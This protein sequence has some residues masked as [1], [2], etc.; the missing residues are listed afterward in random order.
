LLLSSPDVRFHIKLAVCQWLN[1]VASPSDAEFLIVSQFDQTPDKFHVLFRQAV[2]SPNWFDL[3]NHK[4]WITEQLESQ[5]SDR[6]EQMFW[7]FRNIAEE[8]PKEIADLLRS[9]WNSKPIRAERLLDWFGFVR[10]NKVD[11]QLLDLCIELIL[12]HPS[13]LFRNDH[14]VSM[15]LHNWGTG[16]PE[17]CGRVL[18]ALF[19]AW[20]ASTSGDSPFAKNNSDCLDEHRLKEISDKMPFAF[21]YGTTD[22][23]IKTIDM[24]ADNVEGNNSWHLLNYRV[25]SGHHYGFDNFLAC[26][27]SAL[28]QAMKENP[29]SAIG[30]LDKLDPFKHECLMHLHL[31]MIQANPIMLGHRLPHLVSSANIFDAGF[32]GANWW[33]FAHACR[34]TFPVLDMAEKQAVERVILNCYPEIEHSKYLRKQI[35]TEGESEP[36]WTKRSVIWWL[37]RTGYEQWCILETIGTN[38]LT[39]SGQTR[40][41]ALQRKFPHQEIEQPRNYGMYRIGS[42][43]K[44]P[45]CEKMSDKHWL[46]AIK[47]YDNDKERRRGPGF[48][49]GGASDLGHLLQELT[50]IQPDSFAAL[51]LKIPDNAPTCYI[52][53]ILWGLAE[54]E[55]VTDASLTHAI[56]RAY[57]HPSKDFGCAIARVID[58]HPRAV[59]DPEVLELMLKLA[60]HGKAEGE[61]ID[62]EYTERE[63]ITI[64]T[65]VQT[66]GGL[67]LRGING[68]RG[69]MWET[70]ATSAWEIPGATPKIWDALDLALDV[71]PL[72]SVRCNMM[73]VMTPLFNKDKTRFSI[74]IRKLITL[75]NAVTTTSKDR[76]LSP[77]VTHQ[78]LYL[79]P[80]ILHWLPELGKELLNRLL[81]CGDETKQLIGAWLVFGESY[82]NEAYVMKADQLAAVSLEHQRLLADVTADAFSWTDNRPRAERLLKDYFFNEDEQIRKHASDVFN[83]TDIRDISLYRD[84]TVRFIESPAF[85]GNV[86][87]V[88]RMLE[89]ATGDVLELVILI[90]ERLIRDAKLVSQR[91]GNGHYLESLI[92]KE[93]AASDSRP[94]ARRRILD[95]IDDMLANEIYG[96]DDIVEA[97]DRW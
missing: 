57:H 11:D 97:H 32:D 42:P 73:K 80:Y 9:W 59:A 45:Q 68:T 39:Q 1:S 10:L 35:G 91:N 65:L 36:F 64:D 96:A 75:P 17:Q 84:L 88:L 29:E 47:R 38:S 87:R 61:S 92:K 16:S 25:Y 56:K 89:D 19:E 7:W 76:H 63:I 71:E 72:V 8:H 30:F 85:S 48:V 14:T 21:L 27:R 60:L 12:A 82:R 52:E 41:Q 54:A 95:V 51:S 55:T 44:R 5:H 62:I 2:L 67:C 94:D 33:S 78:G 77:L 37:N 46:A 20:F 79:F 15:V 58:K 93:Y 31:E 28:K 22:A 13:E 70:L 4:G 90:S 26:Y 34:E 83:K 18:H 49:D 6:V 50:K 53:Q 3:L 40:L 24:E 81:E 69:R 23:L 43:I 74:S 86:H 66:G